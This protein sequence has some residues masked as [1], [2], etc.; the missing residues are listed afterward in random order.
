MWCPNPTE[1]VNS[2]SIAAIVDS[3]SNPTLSL[4]SS[5]TFPNLFDQ[6]D[7]YR[8]KEPEIYDNYDVDVAESY[9]NSLRQLMGH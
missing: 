2:S 7:G 4:P 5:S 9:T 1:P 6:S 3:S 8:I